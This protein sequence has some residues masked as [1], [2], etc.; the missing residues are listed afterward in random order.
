MIEQIRMLTEEYY[1]MDDGA[2]IDNYLEEI[3]IFNV[4]ICFK[5]RR[6]A[7]KHIV[8]QRKKDKYSVERIYS[9][10]SILINLAKTGNYTITRNNTTG[11]FIL[12]ERFIKKTQ[13]IFIALEIIPLTSNTYYIKT[14]FFRITAKIKTTYF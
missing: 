2:L 12:T 4:Q 13:T 10:F 5:I 14:G 9:L 7:L 11:T 8:E 6:R 3:I 1:K